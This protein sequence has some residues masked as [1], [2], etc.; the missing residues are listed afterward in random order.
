MGGSRSPFS[1]LRRQFML[2]ANGVLYR[3]LAVFRPILAK[4]IR[5]IIRMLKIN[6]Y[7]GEISTNYYIDNI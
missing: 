3:E 5:V 2:V 6:N 7:Y 4:D 1:A